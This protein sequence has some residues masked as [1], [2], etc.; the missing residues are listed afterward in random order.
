MVLSGISIAGGGLCG[1]KTFWGN[2][3]GYI[4]GRDDCGCGSKCCE[5]VL[6]SAG[7]L[8]CFNTSLIFRPRV[9]CLE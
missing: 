6:G 3:F 7:K 5:P 9:T 2:T 1:S 8:R 4:L